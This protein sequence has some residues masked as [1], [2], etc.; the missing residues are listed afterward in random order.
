MGVIRRTSQC[1]RGCFF[2]FRF[3]SDFRRRQPIATI[4]EIFPD[5]S[6]ETKCPSVRNEMPSRNA[7]GNRRR[8][9]GELHIQTVNSRHGGERHFRAAIKASRPGTWTT[10]SVVHL[11]VLPSHQTPRTIL[12]AAG[13]LPV[14]R[15]AEPMQ[16]THQNRVPGPKWQRVVSVQGDLR[17]S[18]HTSGV[19]LPGHQP[20]RFRSGPGNTPETKRQKA[21]SEERAFRVC[22][23]PEKP[24]KISISADRPVRDARF[25]I[26]MM[27]PSP[28]SN[29]TAPFVSV[30]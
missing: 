19:A 16:F 6:S 21:R 30:A 17:L 1:L 18:V 7:R 29:T 23:V 24:Q 15:H 2:A 22:P 8:G 25:E 14:T 12:A 26:V 11:A 28:K 10:P 9:C 5:G 3:V 13:T 4:Q 27:S 20:T